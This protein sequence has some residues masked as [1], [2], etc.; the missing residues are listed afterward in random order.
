MRAYI[1]V[2]S[3]MIDGSGKGKTTVIVDEQSLQLGVP[4]SD[5]KVDLKGLK[6]A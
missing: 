2:L 1:V 5:Q 3:E 4:I 6:F